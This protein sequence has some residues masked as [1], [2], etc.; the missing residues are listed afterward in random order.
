[1]AAGA[2]ISAGY[3]FA[4]T[5]FSYSTSFTGGRAPDVDAS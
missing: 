5:G 4:F 2:G 3:G 1:M